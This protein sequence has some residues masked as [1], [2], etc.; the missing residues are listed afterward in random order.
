MF[1]SL[2]VLHFTQKRVVP[3]RSML[4]AA[5]HR[6]QRS[7]LVTLLI[8]GL[9]RSGK[10]FPLPKN[11]VRIPTL[12]QT[13]GKGCFPHIVVAQGKIETLPN[14]PVFLMII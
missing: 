7:P 5:P 12:P 13:T 11:D 8:E 1:L 4:Y 9:Y 6:K 2:I 10:D 14:S 3:H